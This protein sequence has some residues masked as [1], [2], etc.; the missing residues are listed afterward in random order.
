MAMPSG[1]AEF[2]ADSHADGERRCRGHRSYRRHHDRAE[3]DEVGLI[4][5]FF[6]SESFVSLSVEREIEL[7][8]DSVLL[9]ERSKGQTETVSPRGLDHAHDCHFQTGCPP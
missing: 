3:A 8:R 2:A 5:G 7:I 9:T 1:F 4:N 6:R